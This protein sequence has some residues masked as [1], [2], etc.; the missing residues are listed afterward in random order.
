MITEFESLSSRFAARTTR[1]NSSLVDISN[2]IVSSGLRCADLAL[3]FSSSFSNRTKLT[4]SKGSPLRVIP[5]ISLSCLISGRLWRRSWNIS[6]YKR[7]VD[8]SSSWRVKI[9]AILWI[10]IWQL[11]K[12]SFGDFCV[13]VV[14]VVVVASDGDCGEVIHSGSGDLAWVFRLI[15]ETIKQIYNCDQIRQFDN[16]SW[17]Y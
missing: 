9:F 17:D 2:V 15:S 11:L 5:P 6:A 7:N 12:S 8:S 1:K 3:N 10:V 14:V 4:T 16:C 13:V